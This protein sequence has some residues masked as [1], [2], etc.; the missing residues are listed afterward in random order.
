MREFKETAPATKVAGR[1]GS[2]KKLFDW[3]FNHLN[4]VQIFLLIRL[5]FLSSL[6]PIGYFWITT[7]LN[8]IHLIDRQLN[9]L[10]E[11]VLLRDLFKQIQEH[12]LFAQR[13]FSGDKESL[14][15]MHV[16]ETHIR[17]TLHQANMLALAHQV[18]QTHGPAIWEEINPTEIEAKWD[19]IGQKFSGLSAG[20]S[21]SLHTI[22]L[23]NMVIEFAYL[24]DRI[25]ISYFEQIDKYILIEGMFLR[26]ADLQEHV[27][28]LVLIGE[29]I[30]RHSSRE[31]EGD[32][33]AGV[34]DMIESDI[35]YIGRGIKLHAHHNIDEE[36]SRILNLMRIYRE[37][38]KNL[39]QTVETRL[40]DPSDPTMTLIEFQ[41]ESM[42]A[43]KT[44]YQLWDVGLQ[45][46]THIFQN[47]RAYVLY[48]LWAIV[49]ITILLAGIG[50]FAGL[51]TTYGSSQRLSFLTETTDRFANGDLSVRMPVL[52]QDQIGRQ[53]EAFN[54]MA[55]KLE[56]MIHHL[57]ELLEATSSLAKGNLT[58]RIDIGGHDTEFDQVALSFNKM[59]ETFETIIRRL[60]Q[61]GTVLTASASEISSSLKEQ[62]AIV[63]KQETTTGE[64]ALAANE[65]SSTAKEFASTMNEI[66][67]TA[68]QT[69]HLAL[70]GKDALNN[71]ESIM[72]KMVDAS[73]GIGTKLAILNE[74]ASNI[75]SVITTISKVADKTNLLSLNASIEAEKAG[76]YGRSFAVIAR[77]I[78]RLADQTAIATLDIEKMV[79]EIMTAVSSSVKGVDDFTQ[80]IR[81]GVK[82]V[83][84]VSEQ[85]ATII[86]QVQAFTS[87]FQ[88]VNEGMQ[89]QSTGAEQINEAIAQLSQTARQTSEA[90][91]QFHKTVQEL[92]QV[93]NELSILNPFLT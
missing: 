74:K 1:M 31:L 79:N 45:V 69:S 81:N 48:R 39:I 93:A 54:R 16:L 24:N 22:F 4:S 65:I 40:L 82:Q 67:Q 88:L 89:G 27:S 29:K 5:L 37:N 19:K 72:R 34:I 70:T 60:Q 43:I 18:K 83:R 86:E 20:E 14:T 38:I 78:R 66:S 46:L 12:R 64:I 73:T 61:I 11:E 44:G 10:E 68:E 23:H 49:C 92:N 84:T 41:E 90:I 21:E 57:Y 2:M 3:I 85:L 56:E 87:R 62:E 47:E 52:Y 8:Q 77:E 71:M 80:E 51:I 63:V 75:T 33:A 35:D 55:Q 53:A 50:F 15:E 9:E 13:Y 76:E 32:R 25:G 28:K 59:A 26:L 58:A 42:M 6:L 30:L 7:H 36:H 17:E 91:H